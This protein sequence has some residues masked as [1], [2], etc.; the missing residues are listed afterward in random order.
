MSGGVD[1]EEYERSEVAST[2]GKK[3]RPLTTRKP[4]F[5]KHTNWKR[6]HTHRR[7]SLRGGFVRGEKEKPSAEKE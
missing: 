1:T 5:P 6:K 4:V 3:K 2:T 7:L